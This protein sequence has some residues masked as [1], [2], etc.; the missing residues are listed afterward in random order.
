M[1]PATPAQALAFLRQLA[2]VTSKSEFGDEAFAVETKR[3]AAVAGQSLLLRLAPADLTETLRLPGARP[4]VSV[5]AMGRHCWVQI[6]LGIVDRSEIERLITGA[7]AGAL[8]G[9]RRSAIKKPSRA[10]HIRTRKP[11]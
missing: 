5:G 2:G 8:S 10:R 1:E 7:H 6:K 11:T 9:H 4:F 3:F